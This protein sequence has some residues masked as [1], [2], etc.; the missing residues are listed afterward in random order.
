MIFLIILLTAFSNVSPAPL[1]PVVTPAVI[2]SICP[3]A[4]NRSLC[5]AVLGPAI[6]RSILFN[7]T[8]V[9][10]GPPIRMAQSSATRAR[11]LAWNLEK[12]T[13]TTERT[14]RKYR[15]CFSS[16][17]GVLDK[18]GKADLYMHVHV[19]TKTKSVRQEVGLVSGHVESCD[20]ELVGLPRDGSGLL[21]ANG[22]IKDLCSI[23]LAICDFLKDRK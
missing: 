10:C 1:H 23:V 16:Y 21:E 3:K 2:D 14:R 7:L 12:N 4:S 19:Q 15:M 11:G 22:R 13:N 18:L 5:R 6:G 9:L 20:K 17:K 8:L